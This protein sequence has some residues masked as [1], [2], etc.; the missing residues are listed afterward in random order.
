MAALAQVCVYK[1]THPVEYVQVGSPS[2]TNDGGGRDLVIPISNGVT[3][4]VE[5]LCE[6]TTQQAQQR[7]GGG[8][9]ARRDCT[10][11][12]IVFTQMTEPEQFEQLAAHVRACVSSR[13]RAVGAAKDANYVPLG[14]LGEI[15]NS[16]IHFYHL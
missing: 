15:I 14:V 10:G 8:V 7:T 16:P 13:N 4:A 11:Q 9:P 6:S 1:H 2:V 3:L 12:L 5:L